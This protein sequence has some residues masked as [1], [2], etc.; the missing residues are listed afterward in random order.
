[1]RNSDVTPLLNERP[2]PAKA[3]RYV[4]CSFGVLLAAALGTLSLS[5][6]ISADART[7]EV[8]VPEQHARHAH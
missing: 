6:Q 1:M 4:A 3:W 5:H 8:V 7:H 2:R